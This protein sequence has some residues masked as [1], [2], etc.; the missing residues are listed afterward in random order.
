MTKIHFYT[1]L[2]D[3]V[4]Y[5]CNLV[6]KVLQRGKRIVVYSRNDDLLKR[7]DQALWSFQPLSFVPH[8]MRDDTLAGITPVLLAATA[9]EPAEPLAHHEVLV[10]L[11]Q[12]LPH[13]FSRFDYL[14]ELVGQDSQDNHAARERWKFYKDR[15]YSIEHH[16]KSEM[17]HG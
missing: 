9:P 2:P 14:M 6:S 4:S 15:G 17:H 3:K 11:D 1:G 7:F 12:E 8:V 10:N 5:A 13:F 16:P